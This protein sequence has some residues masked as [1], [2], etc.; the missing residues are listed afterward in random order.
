MS[1]ILTLPMF[2]LAGYLIGSIPFGLVLTR[3]AGLGDIRK[4]GSGNIGTTNVL[5]TGKKWLA[6]ATLLLDMSKAAAAL[7]LYRWLA[8]S[9][10]G[11]YS[12]CATEST[13]LYALVVGMAAVVGHNYP[14]WLRFKGGKGVATTLGLMLAASPMVGLSCCLI[15][16]MVAIVSHISSLSALAALALA[17]VLASATM[18]GTPYPMAYF[19]LAALGWWRHKDNIKRLLKG[20]E[21][22]I[23]FK[24]SA[25]G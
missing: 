17:P 5:R 9:G 23:S 10:C 2:V 15:W 14:V 22:K 18:A 13:D 20:Q 19:M 1:H 25:N 11:G 6:L 4:I 12:V 3:M 16:L 8:T 24:K 21:S 7:E